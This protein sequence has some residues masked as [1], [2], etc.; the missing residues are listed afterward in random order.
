VKEQGYALDLEEYKIGIHCVGVP[1]FNGKREAI[2]TI[3][4]TGPAS[5]F[6]GEKMEEAKNQLVI[7]SKDISKAFYNT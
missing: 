7:V 1:I 3:S 6:T 4:I 2:A 5:R